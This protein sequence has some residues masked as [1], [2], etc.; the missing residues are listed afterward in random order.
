[1]FLLTDP[2]KFANG[3]L[4]SKVDRRLRR[5]GLPDFSMYPNGKKYQTATNIPN[6]DKIYQNVHENTKWPLN[7]PKFSKR[8]SKMYKS[9]HFWCENIP[10]GNPVGHV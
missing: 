3:D 1:M 5:P 6:G 9:W 2:R 4:P 7:T 8:L 10:S